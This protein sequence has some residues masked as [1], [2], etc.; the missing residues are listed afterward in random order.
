MAFDDETIDVLIGGYMSKVA[1]EARGCDGA[2]SMS[3]RNVD[4]PGKQRRHALIS[5][6]C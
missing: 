5:A 1:P 4:V 3:G 2:G 6:T